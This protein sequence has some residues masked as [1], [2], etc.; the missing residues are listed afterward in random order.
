MKC[1]RIFES[2]CKKKK[3]VLILK[4][5]YI[6]LL[7]QLHFFFHFS[8]NYQEKHLNNAV[9]MSGISFI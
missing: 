2:L 5:C 6:S 1:I 9:F 8:V 4:N 7:I 3:I